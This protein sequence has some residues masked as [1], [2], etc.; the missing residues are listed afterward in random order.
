M[1]KRLAN[2][3]I[4]NYNYTDLLRTAIDIALKQTYLQ[5]KVI[6]VDDGGSK[7]NNFICINK[8][9]NNL[10]PIGLG[11]YLRGGVEVKSYKFVNSYL[12]SFIAE[13]IDINMKA[14]YRHIKL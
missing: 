14:F 13:K 12:S 5:I 3:I 10:F 9:A 7:R 11:T 6:L 1:N 2:T 8:V 4:N